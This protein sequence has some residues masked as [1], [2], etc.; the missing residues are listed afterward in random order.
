MTTSTD[1]RATVE[2]A[3]HEPVQGVFNTQHSTPYNRE[4]AHQGL[5][6]LTEVGSTMHGV[7]QGAASDDDI[8]EM[9][10]CIEPPTEVIGLG[11]FEQ[12]EYRTQPVNAR[13]GP[14]DI[15]RCIYGLRKWV[16]LAAAGNPTVLMPLFAN[17]DTHVRYIN[18]WGEVL[19][20]SKALFISK[21]AGHKFLGYLDGQRSRYLDPGRNDS[22]HV[23]RPELV[24][25][26]G[27]D[28]KT[29]Y[30]ALRLAIQGQELMDTGEIF[31]PMRDCNRE[32]LLRVRNGEFSKEEVTK[33]LDE[34]YIPDLKQSI[35]ASSLPEK[36][37]YNVI[38]EWLVEQYETFWG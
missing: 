6:L 37:D 23:S 13:S 32:F 38:N 19:R 9:G 4:I 30:H 36:P 11:K 35:E 31:L 21:Q 34:R 26:Y 22:K 16:R 10:I 24:A 14:G 1:L 33:R 18:L 7:S 17:T 2:Q 27:W 5:I 20:E 8:D 25:K 28:T 3:L 29:G 12:Y 15:D